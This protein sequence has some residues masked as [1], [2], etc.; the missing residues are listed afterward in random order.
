MSRGLAPRSAGD[1]GRASARDEAARGGLD[2]PELF[3]LEQ[4]HRD[5]LRVELRARAAFQLAAR[6]PRGAAPCGRRGRWSSRRRC[7]RPRRCGRSAGCGRPSGP[8]GSPSRPTLVVAVAPG[9][10]V[11]HE[12]DRL[13]DALALGRVRLEHRQLLVRQLAGLVQ[14]SLR[15]PILP[16]SCIRPTLHDRV[17]LGAAHPAGRPRSGARRSRRARSG[18]ACSGPTS[19]ARARTR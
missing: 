6:R 19:R 15:T 16:T 17:D 18:R 7:R 12:R 11:A 5:D 9:D 2:L 8:A 1:W 13:E 4:E 10:D 3:D 14:L